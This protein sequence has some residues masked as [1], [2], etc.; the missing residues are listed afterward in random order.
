MMEWNSKVPNHFQF[1]GKCVQI[2]HVITGGPLCNHTHTPAACAWCI[3]FTSQPSPTLTHC[4]LLCLWSLGLQFYLQIVVILQELRG[5]V[6]QSVI[7][8]SCSEKGPPAAK[9]RHPQYQQCHR[10]MTCK[11]HSQYFYSIRFRAQLS[12]IKCILWDNLISY[13]FALSINGEFL[14]T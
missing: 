3:T 9:Q 1:R 2:T 5:K 12:L 6:K 4:A 14:C 8:G 13:L 11:Y 10:D 7:T